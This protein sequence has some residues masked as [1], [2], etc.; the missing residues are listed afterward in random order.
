VADANHL[1]DTVIRGLAEEMVSRRREIRE[2]EE[3]RGELV[4][5]AAGNGANIEPARLGELDDRLRAERDALAR[6]VLKIQAEGVQV[7]DV[8]E[9]LLDFPAKLAGEDV[10]L[11]WQVGEAEIAWF[12]G[13]EDG[14]AGRR[15]LP[16]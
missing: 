11:C 13:P 14:F 2:L 12:H 16:D 5:R 10:L 6:C 1:L 7:K 15:P 8:D 4:G 9:G 3:A